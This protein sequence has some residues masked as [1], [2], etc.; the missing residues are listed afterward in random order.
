MVI[1]G[2][3]NSRMKDFYDLYTL[4]NRF[5]FDGAVLCNAIQATFARRKTAIPCET[6]IAL[7][8]EFIENNAKLVQ[9]KAFVRKIGSENPLPFDEVIERLR[10]FFCPSSTLF[11]AMV[12][13]Q[14]IGRRMVHGHRHPT[15]NTSPPHLSL[16]L[17]RIPPTSCPAP[18]HQA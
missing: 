4:T 7:G 13:L 3:A 8:N 12:M 9:W 5:E 17:G 16:R 2:I 1:L 15:D 11:P 14:H 6:P 18:Q 10:S